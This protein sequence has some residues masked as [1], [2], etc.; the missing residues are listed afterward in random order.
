MRQVER[1]RDG[2]RGSS[3]VEVLMAVVLT[4]IA[5]V[6]LMGAS[7]ALVR[8]SARNSTQVE[9][10][11]NNAADRVNRAPAGC[12]YSIYV[13]AASMAEGWSPNQASA[14]YKYF[15]PGVDA[16]TQGSWSTGACPNGVRPAGLVQL[17]R[18]TVT[19]PDGIVTRSIQ[20][21]KSDV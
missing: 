21:V 18:V 13:Q 8:N 7:W 1:V 14:T 4:A 11:I 5:I 20:V 12:D 10:V 9:T 19:S 2:D 16:A 17:V 6:P 3:L 15:V